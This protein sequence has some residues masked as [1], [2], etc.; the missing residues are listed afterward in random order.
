MA[1]KIIIDLDGIVFEPIEKAFAQQA[2][3]KFGPV[4]GGAMVMAYKYGPGRSFFYDDMLE[5]FH[6]CAMNPKINSV[7]MDAISKLVHLPDTVVEVCSRLA[8]PGYA[9]VVEDNYRA[10]AP[11]MDKIREYRLVSPFASIRG[12]ICKMTEVG[13][14]YSKDMHV[15]PYVVSAK[16]NDLFWP[17]R[18]RIMPVLIGQEKKNDKGNDVF[19]GKVFPGLDTFAE[20]FIRQNQK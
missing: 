4:K 20:Y 3:E 12:H 7:A 10:I 9:A 8:Y 18:W 15:R 19:T 11:C 5:T 16:I 13:R 2:R 17:A 6:G 14:D 1:N